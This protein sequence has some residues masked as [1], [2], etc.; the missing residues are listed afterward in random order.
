MVNLLMKLPA[1]SGQGI[2]M[3]SILFRPKEGG[4]YNP[5]YSSTSGSLRLINFVSQN[6]SL[7]G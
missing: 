3:D 6:Q 5:Q 4:E 1:A 2:M 7:T